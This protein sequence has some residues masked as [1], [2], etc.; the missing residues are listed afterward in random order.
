M[1]GG[2][3]AELIHASVKGRS[4]RLSRMRSH[5]A[6]TKRK[7][8]STVLLTACGSVKRRGAPGFSV[9]WAAAYFWGLFS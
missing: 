5:F 3:N 4:A 8:R 1:R 6:F 9:A 2:G 7:V